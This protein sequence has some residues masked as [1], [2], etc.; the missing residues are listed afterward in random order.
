MG[1]EPSILETRSQQRFPVF[2]A[3]DL[4]RVR[5]FGII[6]QYLAGATVIAAGEPPDGLL[7]ILSGTVAVSARGVSADTHQIATYGPG[8]FVGELTDL[9]GRPSLVTVKALD[10]LSALVVS[11]EEL[12][13]LLKAEPG[14]GERVMRALILRHL[15]PTQTGCAIVIGPRA[16]PDVLRLESFFRQHG[17]SQQSLD[18]DNDESARSVIER[19][20]V[21]VSELPIVLCPSGRLLCNPTEGDLQLAIGFGMTAD[22]DGT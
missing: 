11:A 14:V 3:P 5:R 15:G 20:K 12:H 9:S 17:Q 21:R 10:P 7:F 6:R 4:Q 19:F 13:A 1:D 8:A 16:S 2:T 18:R 22:P